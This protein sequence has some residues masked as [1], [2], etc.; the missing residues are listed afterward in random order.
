MLERRRW[1]EEEDVR[2][3]ERADQSQECSDHGGFQADGY[4]QS[5]DEAHFGG[6]LLW[7]VEGE[8]SPCRLVWFHSSDQQSR[9]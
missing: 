7:W 4:R 9:E 5:I 1:K 2:D 6:K 3:G 8:P